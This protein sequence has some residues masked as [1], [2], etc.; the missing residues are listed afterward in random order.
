MLRQKTTEHTP[1]ESREGEH[2]IPNRTDNTIP[3][4]NFDQRIKRMNCDC[5]KECRNLLGLKIHR[6]KMKCMDEI[7]HVLRTGLLPDET[8]EVYGQDSHQSAHSLHAIDQ[9]TP[10]RVNYKQ[11]KWPSAKCKSEWIQFDENLSE[12]TRTT[13]KGNADR[14]LNVLSTII[15]SYAKDRFGLREGKKEKKTTV[16]TVGQRR[17]RT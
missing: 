12:T 14:R 7:G 11:I 6:T 13:S 15:V 9:T 5:R 8:K 1:R 3:T 10:C 2:K 17:C 4:P 16:R